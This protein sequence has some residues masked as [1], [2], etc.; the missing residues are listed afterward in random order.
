MTTIRDVIFGS[1]LGAW[2][3]A[4]EQATTQLA[5]SGAVPAL[6]GY[7][8]SQ[9]ARAALGRL[10]EVLNF[11]VSGVLVGGLGLGT[12]LRKAARETAA[13]PGSYRQVRLRTITIPWDRESDVDVLIDRKTVCSLTFVVH[14]EIE[15]AALAAIVRGG[16]IT[17]LSAGSGTLRAQLSARS[18]KPIRVE[19]PLG[20][21]AK[22][23]DP[24]AEIP[25]P[26]NG[27]PLT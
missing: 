25:L 24:K 20:G 14:L 9:V 10:S 1:D 11:E 4:A 19:V 6:S 5:A 18:T 2:G 17:D 13:S 21:A 27:I 23:F 22:D 8:Q 7:T 16:R 12:A 3:L 15:L 26:A